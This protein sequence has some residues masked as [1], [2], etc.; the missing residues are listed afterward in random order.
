MYLHS[1]EKL[2][3][4]QESLGLVEAIYRET[5]NYPEEEKFGLIMQM[6]RSSVSISSNIAE[7]TSR[8]TA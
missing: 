5:K 1:F 3:V 7:G 8:I 4:W 6:R 2:N